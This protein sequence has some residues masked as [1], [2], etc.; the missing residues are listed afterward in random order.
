MGIEL[1]E[2]SISEQETALVALTQLLNPDFSAELALQRL[3]AASTGGMR[4]LAALEA[5]EVLG[6]SGFW[7]NDKVYSGRYLEIDNF[8]VFAEAQGKGIGK[9]LVDGIEQIARNEGCHMV[10][11]DTYV[12]NPRS[13]KFYFREGYTIMGFHFAKRM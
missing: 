9:L 10:L 3:H 6:A 7:V 8:A 4:I 12:S 5:G 2:I 1:K 11:L 13:H